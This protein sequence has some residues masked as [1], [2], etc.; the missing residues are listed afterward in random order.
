[1]LGLETT[2]FVGRPIEVG[3]APF[4]RA[5]WQDPQVGEWLGGV[6]DDL[7]VQRAVRERVADWEETPFGVWLFFERDNGAFIGYCGLQPCIVLDNEEVELV[8]A[9]TSTQWGGGSAT[10]MAAAVVEYGFEV[11]GLDEIVAFTMTNNLAS[12]RVM[13]R[14]GFVY[15]C[16]F[17]HADLPHAL[18][19][20][21]AKQP[22]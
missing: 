22:A 21:Q 2:R 1:M 16:D 20:R 6:R 11:V 17:E 15:D 4:L 12:R 14:N 9:V 8:Y 13:E 10:E 19:R 18:Y 3:D 5:V 7:H